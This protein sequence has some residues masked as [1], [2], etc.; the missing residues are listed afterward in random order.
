[1]VR[2]KGKL[3]RLQIGA[4]YCFNSNMV[5]LK[6]KDELLEDSKF[7]CFNSNMVRLKGYGGNSNHGISI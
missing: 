1:M 6:V 3:H 5:R 7:F 4:V 2:L